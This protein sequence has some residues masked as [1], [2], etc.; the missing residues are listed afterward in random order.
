[1]CCLIDKTKKK[2]IIEQTFFSYFL[3]CYAKARRI[4]TMT[5]DV[6]CNKCPYKDRNKC[7]NDPYRTFIK[8]LVLENVS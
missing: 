8:G 2:M 7:S 3:C 6:K 5:I 1:M 4:K